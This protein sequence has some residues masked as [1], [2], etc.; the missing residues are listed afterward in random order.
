MQKKTVLITGC[1]QGGLGE[2]LVRAFHEKGYYVF[3][4]L[5][6]TAK[7]GT[8]AELDDVEILELEVT[9]VDS[10]QEA[11]QAVSKRTNGT[12]DVLVNNAGADFVFP[13]L[14]VNLDDAKRLYDLNVWS[15]VATAQA[16]TP[17][18]LKTHGTIANICSTAACMPFAWAGTFT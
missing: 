13:L 3:A 10:I 1:S 8:L 17:L 7:A 9:S 5:R 15:I 2:A 18:L 14:D 12:L 11:A 4:T 16:F 6:N